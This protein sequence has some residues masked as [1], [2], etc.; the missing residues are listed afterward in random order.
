MTVT[1][2]LVNANNRCV[3]ASVTR[4]L[5]DLVYP[6][7]G[8]WLSERPEPFNICQRVGEMAELLR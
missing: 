3:T 7:D 6:G 8:I 1:L 4:C 5:R 2:D